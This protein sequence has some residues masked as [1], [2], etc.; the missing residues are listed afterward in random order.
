VRTRYFSAI[1][2][3]TWRRLDDHVED[4]AQPAPIAT[5]RRGGCAKQYRIGI[6]LDDLAIGLRRRMMRLVDD[7]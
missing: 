4:A 7:Q 2:S 3:A 5:A 6:S 1:S